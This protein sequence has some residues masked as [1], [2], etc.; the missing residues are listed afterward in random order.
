M[1][2]F[3]SRLD[4]AKEIILK[5]GEVTEEITQSVSERKKKQMENLKGK[6]KRQE[7]KVLSKRW[8]EK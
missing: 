8:R 5:K 3:N 6:L 4:V 2:C 1:D 7:E